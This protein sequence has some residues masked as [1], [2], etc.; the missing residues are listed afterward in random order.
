V[1]FKNSPALVPQPHFKTAV[2]LPQCVNHPLFD[3]PARVFT[4]PN[5]AVFRKHQR[6][7]TRASLQSASPYGHPLYAPLGGSHMLKNA[8]FLQ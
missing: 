7:I 6:S 2:M 3:A 1:C 5:P 8:Y 4:P